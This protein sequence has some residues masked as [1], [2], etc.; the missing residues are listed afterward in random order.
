MFPLENSILHS[1]LQ[2]GQRSFG[3]VY[4]TLLN[5][6]MSTSET[7]EQGDDR[8]SSTEIE[9]QRRPRKGGKS[10]QHKKIEPTSLTELQACPFAVS[11]FQHMA[12]YQFCERLSHIQPHRELA[13]L[14]VLHLHDG[15]VTLAGVNFVFS[16]EAIT[17]ATGIPNVGEVWLKRKWLDFVYYEPY[18][19]A[20]CIHN[21]TGTFPIKF[22]RA[23]YMDIMRLI[24]HY[25]TCEGRFARVSAYHI[26][27][28]MHFT[29][30]R[31]MNIAA[32]LFHDTQRLTALFQ[33]QT[34][35][36][37]LRSLCHHGLIQLVVSHQLGQQ[38]ISWSDFI[39]HEVFSA[40]SRSQPESEGAH[41]EPQI[42][43]EEGG[44]S[45]QAE[46]MVPT[47]LVPPLQYTYQRGHRTL[48][49]AAGRVL[50]PHQVEGVSS[51]SSEQRV[52]SPHQVEGASLLS[53]A[54][55]AERGKQPMV[56]ERVSGA[57]VI[58][59][60]DDS[61]TPGLK[62]IIQEQSAEIQSLQRKL[63]MSR[64]INT[65]LEQRNKQL[66]DEKE[67]DELWRIRSDRTLQ[68]RRPGDLLRVDRESML[69]RV[70]AHL[71]KLL[72]K[73]NRDKALLRHMKTHYWARLHVSKARNK[74][75]QRKLSEARKRKKKRT[76]PLSILAEA[77]FI[78]HD[79]DQP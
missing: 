76:N 19:R 54:Q 28:L 42:I 64:W 29:R 78:H 53:P 20:S 65:Y 34:P 3:L 72:A 38:G 22:L 24:M 2:A 45:H 71:E 73:A 5:N 9:T 66:E 51:S 75:L 67:L 61:P 56:E 18:V 55:V 36:Q 27:I 4:S 70:N 32:Y 16:P 23:E 43:H 68:R 15:Q 57:P 37:Q 10:G 63:Y 7:N 58:D 49:A 13:R 30:V 77:S 59:L 52:L 33:R 12:C 31:V 48:F 40:P 74:I 50:S 26:R 1:I 41:P 21:L 14:F 69:I 62:D 6:T 8:S 11:C 17:E 47:H 79:I 39:S 60:D 46:I 25:F 35:A 44:P